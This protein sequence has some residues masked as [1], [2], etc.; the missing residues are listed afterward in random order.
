MRAALADLSNKADAVSGN[1]LNIYHRDTITIKLPLPD[2]SLSPNA[3]VHWSK[4]QKGVERLFAK[5][6]AMNAMYPYDG[7]KWKRASVQCVFTFKDRRS[8][9]K[10]NYLAMMKSDFDGFA[11]AEIITNDSGFTY[12]PV[13]FTE[14]DKS[15]VGVVVTITR[16]E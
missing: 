15:A 2:K 6:T 9:D 3:R 10:D 14:P 16:T 7:P 5:L 8:R 12:L 1:S 11:D 4:K 13:V